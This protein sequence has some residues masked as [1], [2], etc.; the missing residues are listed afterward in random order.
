MIPYS[1]K[2]SRPGKL[3]DALVFEKQMHCPI[4]SPMLKCLLPACLLF[5]SAVAGWADEGSNRA[6]SQ[7]HTRFAFSMDDLSGNLATVF[8]EN[9]TGRHASNGYIARMDGKT[10]LFTRQSTLFGA[11][12]ISFK[13]LSGTTLRP[14][15]VELSASRDMARLLLDG[16]ATG[17][18]VS[19]EVSMNSPICIPETGTK[20]GSMNRLT[21]KIIG[22]GPETLEVS[23]L[24]DPQNS[25]SPVLNPELEV[26]GIASYVMEAYKDG[27]T[28]GTQFGY[29]PRYLCYRMADARWKPVDW[30]AYNAKYGGFYHENAVFIEQ[31]GDI[32]LRLADA[33][34][35]EILGMQNL[36]RDLASWTGSFNKV[37]IRHDY[38]NR[39]KQAFAA[40]YTECIKMLSKTCRTR[41]Q[42]IQAF[43]EKR[44][45]TPFLQQELRLQ[46]KT[47]DAIVGLLNRVGAYGK[48]YRQ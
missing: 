3:A 1:P 45:L 39:D 20:A 27:I 36:R 32:A 40:D 9:D 19:D 14:L 30:R 44:G 13:T 7:R 25:G 21:G 48:D 15:G 6:S 29:K 10:Y 11:K 17:F 43:S 42:K 37:A 26:L 18:E 8:C 38:R 24:F 35:G 16:E 46:T 41:A 34:M 47:L 28:K 4:A 12:K 5:L 33:P 23:V 22:V 31:A 2:A